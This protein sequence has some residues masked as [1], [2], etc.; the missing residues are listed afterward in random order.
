MPKVGETVHYIQKKGDGL[1][2]EGENCLAAV[3]TRVVGDK[4]HL[5]VLANQ[6]VNIFIEDVERSNDKAKA[7]CYHPFH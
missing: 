3:V 4:V 1:D 7:G 5:R 2:S 6:P